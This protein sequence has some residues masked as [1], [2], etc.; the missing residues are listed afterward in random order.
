MVDGEVVV[1]GQDLV[2]VGADVVARLL[3]DG[4]ELLTVITGAD[5]GPELSAA[6]AAS[7][8]LGYPDLEVNIIDG[9]QTTYPL[10][11]GVE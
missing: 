3:V 8:H 10:L 11:L 9:G 6:V 5:G 2:V 4:G 7:A 1:I